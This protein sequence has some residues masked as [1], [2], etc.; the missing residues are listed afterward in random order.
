MMRLRILHSYV[1]EV[2]LRLDEGN[3]CVLAE[4]GL[5]SVTELAKSESADRLTARESSATPAYGAR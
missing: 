3:C 4:S 2:T 1:A 5:D